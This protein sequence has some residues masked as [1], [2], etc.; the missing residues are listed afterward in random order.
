MLTIDRPGQGCR[1]YP[2]R[3]RVGNQP[4]HVRPLHRTRLP[5][6][7]AC[8]L[9]AAAQR[10]SLTA[11]PKARA[12]RIAIRS[13]SS[14]WSGRRTQR[15]AAVM[16][17]RSRIQSARCGM[18]TGTPYTVWWPHQVLDVRTLALLIRFGEPNGEPATTATGPRWAT[19][20][21]HDCGQPPLRREC[22]WRMRRYGT[23]GSLMATGTATEVQRNAGQP[24]A[25]GSDSD[26]PVWDWFWLAAGPGSGAVMGGR[27]MY[28]A[29]CQ[30]L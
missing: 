11:L 23:E 8:L 28:G 27:A 25:T 14:A 2:T 21:Y 9:T 12:S 20:S 30:G 16:S 18:L 29:P 24:L 5:T 3:V 4:G 13:G 1:R 15:S 22:Q 7:A 19:S 17:V 10:R 26:A 6:A